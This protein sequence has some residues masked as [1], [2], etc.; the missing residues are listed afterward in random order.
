[1]NIDSKLKEIRNEDYIWIIY[2]IIIFM[3]WYNNG[4]ERKYFLYKNILAKEKYRKVLIIIFTILLLVYIYFF[5]SSL[6]SIHN[7]KDNDSINKKKLTELAGI[8][9]LLILVSGVIFL[10]VA[11]MDYDIEVELAFN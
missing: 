6:D 5:K 8:A 1:M 9:S 2:I 10:Y 3:S 7:L 11:Y 4:L